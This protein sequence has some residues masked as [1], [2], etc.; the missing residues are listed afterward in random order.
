MQKYKLNRKKSF[1]LRFISLRIVAINDL[2][3]RNRR[4]YKKHNKR[5][6]TTRRRFQK[7]SIAL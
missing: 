5:Y 4:E 6:G 7:I 2:F 1:T 3:K